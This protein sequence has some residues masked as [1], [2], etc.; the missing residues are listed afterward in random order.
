VLSV[1][2][3]TINRLGA[4]LNNLAL[5]ASN[6][7]TVLQQLTAANLALTAL[8]TTLTAAGQ[9]EGCHYSGGNVGNARGGAFQ[10]RAFPWKLLLES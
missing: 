8:V 9:N 10:Q 7:T 4:A 2:T 6:N 3:T 5:T 1:P